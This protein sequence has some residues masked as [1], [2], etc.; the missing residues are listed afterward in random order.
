MR[1]KGIRSSSRR[2]SRLV[3]DSPDGEV[4]VP[5]TIQALLAARLDQLDP[6]ERDVLG[7]GSVEGRVFHR[8][9][10]EALS[11]DGAAARRAADGARAE[12]VAAPGWT[13]FPGEDAFRFRHLLIR[14]AAYEAL[15]KAIRAGL[16]ERFAGW[17][18]ERGADLVELDEVVGYHLE[19]A[20]R[21]RV[22]LGPADEAARELSAACRR[23]PGGCG[24]E[25]G[26]P[27]RRAGGERSPRPR[28]LPSAR[29]RCPPAGASCLP[30]GGHCSR[31][32]SG[33]VRTRF[34]RRPSATLAPQATAGWPPTAPSR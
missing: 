13:A 22:A 34:C 16:H 11:P 12:G 3:R 7:R 28:C 31:P 10:V 14:D 8:G 1:R 15:P 27:R 19:R 23:A 6:V 29:G 2:W 33:R 26:C 24:S 4:A 20:Y 25:G 32:G 18:A 17:I 5:A 21:Y 9:A 30:S